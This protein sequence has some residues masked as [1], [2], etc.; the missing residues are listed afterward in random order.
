MKH[1]L[2]FD[3]RVGGASGCRHRREWKRCWNAQTPRCDL[4]VSYCV[5]SNGAATAYAN[6]ASVSHCPHQLYEVPAEVDDDEAD[7]ASSSVA[8][9]DSMR[10]AQPPAFR[11]WQATFSYMQVA[12]SAMLSTS[13]EDHVQM[14]PTAPASAPGAAKPR[15]SM[16]DALVV[17]GTCCL[18]SRDDPTYETAEEIIETYVQLPWCP[19]WS[20]PRDEKTVSSFADVGL[21]NAHQ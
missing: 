12:G 3:A 1:C 10:L 15:L 5:C 2:V 8:M 4:Y 17:S 16:K 6:A 14:L 19:L 7:E 18:Q 13:S 20:E 11:R 9:S 21:W